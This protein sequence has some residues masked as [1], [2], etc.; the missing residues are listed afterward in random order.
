M[1]SPLT[2]DEALDRLKRSQQA[3]PQSTQAPSSLGAPPAPMGATPQ[4]AQPIDQAAQPQATGMSQPAPTMGG[5]QPSATAA[6]AQQAPQAV[7][8]QAG[9]R[10]YP[11]DPNALPKPQEGFHYELGPGGLP[12]YRTDDHGNFLTDDQGRWIPKMNT[13]EERKL[14]GERASQ[15]TGFASVKN[16]ITDARN[17]TG[18]PGFDTALKLSKSGNKVN[19]PYGGGSID[20]TGPARMTNPDSPAWGVL[21]DITAT[22]QRLGLVV[23]RATSKGQGTVSDY[24]RKLFEEA[25]GQLSNSSSKADFQFRLNSVQRMADDLTA[26]NKLGSKESYNSRPTTAELATLKRDMYQAKTPEEISAKVSAMAKKYNVPDADMVEHVMQT[27]DIAKKASPTML[28]KL[29]AFFSS[30]GLPK[31]SEIMD[32]ARKAVR[33]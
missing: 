4:A 10:E 18:Q 27:F 6:P 9:W 15:E 7:A 14:Q 21:D 22:Q 12:Q 3:P 31:D 17:L 33:Q 29:D 20:I 30:M 25:V 5:G 1:P 28:E 26:G 16:L 19:I 23:S 2:L 11:V 8:P 32:A 13:E 24:E